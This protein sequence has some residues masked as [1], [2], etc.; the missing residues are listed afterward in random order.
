MPVAIR[1]ILLEKLHDP[2]IKLCSFFNTIAH[3]V[4]DPATPDKLEKDMHHTMSRLQMHLP[5][6]FF[7]MSV[8]LISH[9]I[10]QI[11]ALGLLFLHQMFPFEWLM[12]VLRKYVWNRY[13]ARRVHGGR[14]V[15]RGGNQVLHIVFGSKSNLCLSWHEGRLHGRGTIGERS[16]RVEVDAF[17]QA[18]FTVLRQASIVSPYIKEHMAEL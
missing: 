7:D 16:V 3:K 14:M 18:H 10:Q 15:D 4:I 13:R 5:L 12:S 17:W 11:R 8:H 2:I 1:G 6:T 9:L